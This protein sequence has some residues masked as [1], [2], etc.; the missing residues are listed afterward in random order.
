MCNNFF[1]KSIYFRISNQKSNYIFSNFNIVLDNSTKQLNFT[2]STKFKNKSKLHAHSN[3]KN[4]K[5]EAVFRAF[6]DRSVSFFIQMSKWGTAIGIFNIIYILL[7]IWIYSTSI[8]FTWLLMLGKLFMTMVQLPC[9]LLLIQYLK[10]IGLQLEQ[11]QQGAVQLLI[12]L[13]EHF[14]WRLNHRLGKYSLY[15]IGITGS[16]VYLRPGKSGLD[17]AMEYIFW[18]NIAVLIFNFIKTGYWLNQLLPALGIGA[19][20]GGATP[21]EIMQN[22]ILSI[23][24]SENQP[25]GHQDQCPICFEEY[26]DGDEIRTLKCNHVYHDNCILSW[27]KNQR[28]CPYCKKVI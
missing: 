5:M 22:T 21:L 8:S 14:V 18:S 3:S 24:N 23:Y 9:K 20:I 27:L 17:Y 19:K 2:I 25:E 10:N 28:A 7:S 13:Q 11:R 4:F 6:P 15:W 12:E 16:M 1:Q 26:K